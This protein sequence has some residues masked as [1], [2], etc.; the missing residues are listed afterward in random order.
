MNGLDN[1]REVERHEV[2]EDTPVDQVITE[3]FI[4]KFEKQ[5]ELFP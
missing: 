5:A 1:Q 2:I 4:A 3:D